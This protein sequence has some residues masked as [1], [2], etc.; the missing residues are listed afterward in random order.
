MKTALQKTYQ[1]DKTG[2]DALLYWVLYACYQATTTDLP[3]RSRRQKDSEIKKEFPS[4]IK[5]LTKITK[6]MK[7][8]PEASSWALAQSYLAWK[9]NHPGYG[10]QC[11]TGDET[12]SF[13]I[14]CEDLLTCY[15][16]ELSNGVTSVKHGN[17]MHRWKTGP[18]L[19]PNPLDQQNAQPQSKV[20]G[21]LFHLAFLFRLYTSPNPH[22][23]WQS[24]ERMPTTGK[25]WIP[26]VTVLTNA[27]LET[28][29]S[30]EEVRSI[31]HSLVK[32]K[33]GLIP[34]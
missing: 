18:L 13:A 1:L 30:I 33:V 28:D 11:N 9:G 6:F 19:Y 2:T 27:T 29:L 12:L 17:L 34:W 24:G 16:T 26:L 20:N 21:L 3:D 31:I 10:I 14:V 32:K 7:R 8:Y 4:Q 25:P 5:A 22:G 15:A 23:R